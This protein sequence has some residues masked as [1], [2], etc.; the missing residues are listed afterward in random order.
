MCSLHQHDIQMHITCHTCTL[1]KK[2]PDH[3]AKVEKNPRAPR[4]E[5]GSLQMQCEIP[6]EY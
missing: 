5:I 1:G 2:N 4:Y 6:R 3:Y